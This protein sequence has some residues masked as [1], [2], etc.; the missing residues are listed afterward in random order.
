MAVMLV[1]SL[2][3]AGVVFKALGVEDYGTYNIVGSIIVFFSFLNNG[4]G[5]ATKRYITAEIAQGDDNS[6]QRVF[7]AAVIAHIIIAIVILIVAET[8]GLWLVNSVLK[9]PENRYFAANIVYQLSVLSTLLG[10][11]Q[12]PF[13]SAILAYERMSIYAYF[14]IFDVVFKLLLIYC[15]LTIDGDKLI[16]YALMVFFTGAVNI[17]IYRIY[18]YRHFDMCKWIFVKDYPLLKNMFT[19]TSWSLLG[20]GAVMASNQGV[21]FLINLFCGVTVNAAMGISNSITKVIN[22]FVLN[23][24]FAFNPQ[25][26]KY[27]VTKDYEGLNLLVHRT[28]RYSSFLVLLFLL[29]IC[30]E[31]SDF[32]FLWLGDYPK[33]SVEFCIFSLVAIYFDALAAPLWMVLCSD[34]DIKK[35]QITVSLVFL[36]NVLFSWI[37]LALGFSP[38]NVM[39]VRFSVS[40][41]L[42]LVRLGF[43]KNK[44]PSFS[45]VLWLKNVL[46]KSAILMVLPLILTYLVS[47]IHYEHTI[48]RLIVVSGSAAL[49]TAVSIFIIGLEPNERQFVIN[50]IKS[51][52]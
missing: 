2:Y 17:I 7:N 34:V 11:M 52:I 27:Y 19:Y 32:L 28:S 39:I 13:T 26:T 37:F 29:P 45:P 25:I 41:L 15:L 40:F 49:F 14:S 6:R 21:S 38:Y 50:K 47:D 20:Q 31:A 12:C 44:V 18:C 3:T 10:I 9:I 46:G 24:Q 35:Y 4:L 22:D 48:L 36:L 1:L 30:F 16:I 43:V 51:K 42:V 23:F 5:T 33:Y 8:L